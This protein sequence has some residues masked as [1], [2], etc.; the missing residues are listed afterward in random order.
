MRKAESLPMNIII[1]AIIGIIVLIILLALFAGKIKI[2]GS[3]V[4]GSCQE[5]GGEC[6]KLAGNEASC[7][8]VQGKPLLVWAVGCD[9]KPANADVCKDKKGMGQCCLPLVR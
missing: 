5:Q 3:N 6:A 2:F 1:I 8:E 4:G 9:C 7:S